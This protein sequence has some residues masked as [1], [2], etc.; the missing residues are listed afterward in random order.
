M[1]VDHLDRIWFVGTG[2]RPNHLVGFSTVSKEFTSITRIPSGAGS[3]RHMVFDSQAKAIW[4]GTDD[5][6]IGRATVPLR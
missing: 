6:T 3:V 1:A 2:D 4:F 5:N